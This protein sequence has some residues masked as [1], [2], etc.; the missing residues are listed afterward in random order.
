M[1]LPEDI[2][3]ALAP[4]D[5]TELWKTVIKLLETSIYSETVQAVGKENK[6]EDRAWHCGRVDA[7]MAFKDVLLDTQQEAAKQLGYLDSS[8]TDTQRF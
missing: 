2:A 8:K 7:L 4:A 5:K 1:S 3:K 6:S